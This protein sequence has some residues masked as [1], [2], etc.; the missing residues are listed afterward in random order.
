MNLTNRVKTLQQRAIDSN[1]ACGSEEILDSF[2]VLLIEDFRELAA[3]KCM[4]VPF[5]Q[6]KVL[7]KFDETI[8]HDYYG[9]T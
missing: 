4:H 9:D 2:A 6:A 3:S 1:P 7:T 8:L 5:I